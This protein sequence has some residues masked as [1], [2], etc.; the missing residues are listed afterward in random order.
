MHLKKGK[1]SIGEIFIPGKLK[2]EIL[3]STYICHPQM[4]N[5]ELSGPVVLIHLSNWIK[6]KKRK[7]SYS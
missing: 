1:L 6:I 3:L 5:N 4:A 2:K 7:F